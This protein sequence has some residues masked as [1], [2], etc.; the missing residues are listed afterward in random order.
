MVRLP[1][2]STG[3]TI[4][5]RMPARHTA[6]MGR[7]TLWGA[8]SLAR[9]PGSVATTAGAFMADGAA[10]MVAVG[11]E[12]VTDSAGAGDFVAKVDGGAEVNGVVA[13]DTVVTTGSAVARASMVVASAAA[14]ASMVGASSTAAAMAADSTEAVD[15]MAEVA[16]PT[17]EVTA[18]R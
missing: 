7:T 6:T 15:F 13:P 9:G 4:M 1:I 2:A 12:T 18:S 8:R 5:L 17:A 10:T 16:G 3:I 14:T 11:M